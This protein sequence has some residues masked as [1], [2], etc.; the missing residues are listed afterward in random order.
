MSSKL[1]WYLIDS[2][3]TAKALFLKLLFT[4]IYFFNCLRTLKVLAIMTTVVCIF[5]RFI[6]LDII[7]VLPDYLMTAARRLTGKR[8]PFV[9]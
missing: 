2:I 7:R 9:T 3:L 6:I 5:K 4:R 8:V 1:L